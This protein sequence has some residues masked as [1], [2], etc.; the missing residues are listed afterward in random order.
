MDQW[1]I[2]SNV[3][4]ETPPSKITSTILKCP[5]VNETRWYFTWNISNIYLNR[6]HDCV[7]EAQCLLNIAEQQCRIEYIIIISEHD[8]YSDNIDK[9]IKTKLIEISLVND[10]RE[11][12]L[13]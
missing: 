13:R 1:T 4:F 7:I 11:S 12:D 6:N 2:T 5:S 9:I 3:N 8:E 10:S